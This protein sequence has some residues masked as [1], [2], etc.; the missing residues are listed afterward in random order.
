MEITCK[1]L[2]NDRY[3]DT[4]VERPE[5]LPQARRLK[6]D[7]YGYDV[8]KETTASQDEEEQ[9][10]KHERVPAEHPNDYH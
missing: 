7:R 10:K 6:N 9:G 5:D 4:V 8:S 2:K 3:A 1:N